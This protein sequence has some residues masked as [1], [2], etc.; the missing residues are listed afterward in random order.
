MDEIILRRRLIMEKKEEKSQLI[1][2]S[3]TSSAYYVRK[4]SSEKTVM[5]ARANGKVKLWRDNLSSGDFSGAAYTSSG[6]NS[7]NYN[8]PWTDT[9]SCVRCK[10]GGS[11]ISTS[12]TNVNLDSAYA[13]W[14]QTGRI[15]FAG[16]NTPYYGM[17]NIDGTLAQPGWS[18]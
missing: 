14:K 13:Y 12:A 8:S 4:S 16:S 3:A 7:T 10:F 11:N 9:T 1:D 2:T 18:G 6:L 17:S 15:M 5:G